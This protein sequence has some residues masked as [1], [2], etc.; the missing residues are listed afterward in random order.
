MAYINFKLRLITILKSYNYN[1]QSIRS[2]VKATD[3]E[4]LF[5]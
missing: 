2:I 1:T 4:L 3:L 5:L